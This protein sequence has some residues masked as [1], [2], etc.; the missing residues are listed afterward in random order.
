MKR[1]L[2]LLQTLSFSVLI[3]QPPSGI[4]GDGADRPA[5][6]VIGE[7]G[8]EA[9]EALPYVNVELIKLSDSSV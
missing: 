6:V 7:I 8:D 9:N 5:W 4:Y 1:L 3:A 2:I